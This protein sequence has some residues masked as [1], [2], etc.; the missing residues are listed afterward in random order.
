M[1]FDS[2]LD[3][4]SSALESVARRHRPSTSVM[5]HVVHRPPLS[6]HSI[7]SKAPTPTFPQKQNRRK[8]CARQIH[9]RPAYF[10]PFFF[11]PLLGVS[12]ITASSSAPLVAFEL[13]S[14]SSSSFMNSLWI[15]PRRL[16]PH[17]R[18]VAAW[19]WISSRL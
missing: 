16:S 1:P 17:S 14:E 8:L 3:F 18:S 7:N 9:A 13:F 10:L 6:Y 4:P 19:D 11:P 2:R 15:C 12:T 5:I